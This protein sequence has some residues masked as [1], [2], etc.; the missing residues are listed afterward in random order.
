MFDAGLIARQMVTALSK[1]RQSTSLVLLLM[2]KMAP[3]QVL[4]SGTQ[5]LMET[6]GLVPVYPTAI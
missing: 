3:S 5:A 6:S 2:M 1:A 4:F